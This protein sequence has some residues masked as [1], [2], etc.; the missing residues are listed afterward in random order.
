MLCHEDLGLNF[1]NTAHARLMVDD[2]TGLDMG[3]ETCHGPG[4]LHSMEGEGRHL[5]HNP[6]RT[7]ATCLQCHMEVQAQFALPNS[8]PVSEGKAACVDCHDPH[9]DEQ[10]DLLAEGIAMAEHGSCLNCHPAQAGPF[11]FEHEAMRDGCTV[12]HDAH[13]SMNAKLLKI[14]NANMCLQCHFVENRQNS[15][16]I[17]G[18]DHTGFGFIQQ[19]TCWTAGCHEAV[20]GSHVNGSLRF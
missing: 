20:H 7:S 16:M 9:G 5:I 6:G 19:G 18:I 2:E 3:C 14:R 13:G 10:A 17:G 8:H 15:L 1:A 11:V 12:C 4:S